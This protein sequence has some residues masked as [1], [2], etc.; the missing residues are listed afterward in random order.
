MYLLVIQLYKIE[1]KEDVLL[2]LTSCGIERGTLLEGTNLDQELTRDFPLFSGLVR[3]DGEKARFSVQITAVV[4]Q[5]ETAAMIVDLLKEADID[6]QDE[7]IL[8][9]MLLPMAYYV[10]EKTH[11]DG[12]LS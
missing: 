1:Y 4:E 6:I 11:W 10:D 9:L 8:R 5:R 12:A 7:A 2:A 3:S